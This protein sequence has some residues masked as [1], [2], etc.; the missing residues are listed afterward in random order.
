MRAA[1][2]QSVMA[3]TFRTVLLLIFLVS[4][5]PVILGSSAAQVQQAQ[6]FSG[7]GTAVL[8]SSMTPEN[9]ERLAFEKARAS[10]LR[11]FGTY[12]RSENVLSTTE[13]SRGI[14][15]ISRAR[16]S[17]LAAGEAQLVGGSKTVHREMKGEAVV[18]HVEARFEIEPNG[19][20]ETLRAYLETEGDAPMN[21][22]VRDAARTQQ[23]LQEIDPESAGDGEVESLLSQAE[24]AYEQVSG[25]VESLNGAAARSKIGRERR[26]RKN[27]LLRYMHAVKEQGHP[28][29]VV[30]MRL[31]RSDIQD[32]GSEVELTYQARLNPS[33]GEAGRLTS[34]CRQTRPTW[35]PDDSKD[36]GIIGR[37]ATDGWLQQ[38]FEDSYLDFE[39]QKPILLYMLDSG[40]D[41]LLVVAKTSKGMMSSPD[42]R[43][44]YGHCSEDNLVQTRLWDREWEVRI[45]TRYLGQIGS[46][47][48][49]VSREDYRELAGKN[50]FKAIDRGVYAQGA[51]NA[52]ALSRFTYSRTR[53]EAFVG[54]YMR[55]V[56]SAGSA[57]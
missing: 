45:P 53:F 16:I 36:N 7:A 21:R 43:V 11:K 20:E 51:G 32:H 44:Q 3:Q 54:K 13:T 1:T 14:E 18:Y 47:A 4:G 24:S 46:V 10:A 48:L 41:V 37:P 31:S 12:V 17:V 25:A 49:A 6:V 33:S 2:F 39:V 52:V 56:R 42:L 9:T 35:A 22:T 57:P 55:R 40:G 5:G 34:T 15:E 27:A 50:G 28:R 29:D 38:I 23:R 26:R 8:G 30:S 19:F